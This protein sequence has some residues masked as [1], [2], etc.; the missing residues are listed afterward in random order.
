MQSL[1]FFETLRVGA[2]G[3]G[4][5]MKM[6]Q[7]TVWKPAERAQDIPQPWAVSTHTS[8]SAPLLPNFRC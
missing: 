6:A 4:N 1:V 2:L 5:R 3:P 8:P 7:W